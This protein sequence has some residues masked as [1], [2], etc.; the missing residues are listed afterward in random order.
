MSTRYISALLSP[1]H[2]SSVLG[3]GLRSTER[4]QQPVKLGVVG[5]LE[6]DGEVRSPPGRPGGMVQGRANGGGPRI[7]IPPFFAAE[8]RTL[9]K[10]TVPGGMS[11]PAGSLA[12]Q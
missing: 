6:A 4:R 9:P 7:S 8:A 1:D 5:T 11:A 10:S 2:A 12:S 3:I